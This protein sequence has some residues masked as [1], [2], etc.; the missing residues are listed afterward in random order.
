MISKPKIKTKS[1]KTKS[2]SN[3]HKRWDSGASR[4]SKRLR[5]LCGS[6]DFDFLRLNNTVN[7]FCKPCT[8]SALEPPAYIYLCPFIPLPCSRLLFLH[9]KMIAKV[10]PLSHQ[11]LNLG[12]FCFTAKSRN[13]CYT[14]LNVRSINTVECFTSDAVFLRAFRRVKIQA[15]E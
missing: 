7:T 1:P 4:N 5:L 10:L 13:S 2:P 11:W 9:H 8:F 15:H 12:S 3:F 6:S 14:L